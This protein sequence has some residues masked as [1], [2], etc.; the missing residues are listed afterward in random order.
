MI[1]PRDNELNLLLLVFELRWRATRP[2]MLL[3]MASSGL[4]LLLELIGDE[5]SA[6]I[7][8]RSS[9]VETVLSSFMLCIVEFWR[10]GQDKSVNLA[11]SV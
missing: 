9:E 3:D 8:S 11:F 6:S 2:S 1:L 4:I 10:E 7:K 5:T